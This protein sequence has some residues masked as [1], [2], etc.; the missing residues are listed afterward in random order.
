[1]FHPATLFPYRLL[2]EVPGAR[3]GETR[4]TRRRLG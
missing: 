1:M 4:E 2:E 3:D